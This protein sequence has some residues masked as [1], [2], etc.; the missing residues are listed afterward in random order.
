MQDDGGHD[1]ARMRTITIAGGCVVSSDDWEAA[2]WRDR[3]A[4][5]PIDGKPYI[6]GYSC[7]SAEVVKAGRHINKIK[8][9]TMEQAEM[10][11]K[12]CRS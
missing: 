10:V 11:V 9:P 12:L 3:V 8:Q 1:A 6:K 2:Y 4:P 7:K 5:K